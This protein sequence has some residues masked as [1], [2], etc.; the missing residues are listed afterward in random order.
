MRILRTT[1]LGVAAVGAAAW[2]SAPVI[3]GAQA[4][5]KAGSAAQ[6]P[7]MAK[8]MMSKDQKIANAVSAAPA[9]IGSN[10]TILDWPA[11][12]GEAPAVLRAGSN[13]WTCMPD[14]PDTE[15]NDPG[16]MDKPWMQWLDAY[17]AHKTPTITTV[18]IGYMIAPGGGWGSNTD[19][20]AT[21]M[22]ADN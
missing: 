7:M 6:M 21:K 22:S 20:Y 10:A 18:G 9:G 3:A 12:E 17:M 5:G 11:K 15:G 16:C 14:M 19:P 13:G 2:L 1:G 8:S 4:K